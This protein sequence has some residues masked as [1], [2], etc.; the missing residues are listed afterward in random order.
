MNKLKEKKELILKQVEK[1]LTFQDVEWS[2]DV[3]KRLKE[4]VS[5]GKMVRGSLFL[6]TYELLGGKEDVLDT[7][8]AIELVHNT[9]CVHDDVMDKDE[10]RRGKQTMHK[11]YES[12]VSD[13][14]YGYSMAICVGDVGFFKSFSLF[15]KRVMDIVSVEL[16]KCG[17]GQMQDI[18]LAYSSREPTKEQI[19]DV[20][21]HK[22]ARYTFSMPMMLAARIANSYVDLFSKLGENLGI[23]FQ[24]IDDDIGIFGDLKEIGK[25]PGSDIVENKKTL[26]RYFLLEKYPEFKKY[27]GTKVSAKE[28]DL[29]KEKMLEIKPKIQKILNHH[30]QEA[31]KLIEKLPCDKTFFEEL[32]NYNLSRLK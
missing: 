19:I 4:S 11:Q 14:H 1:K 22:T 2:K 29:I 16:E 32:S 21:R 23:I 6:R 5:N 17:Y 10:F 28:L 13:T 9:L 7:A 27:F 24:I 26:H 30:Q 20:Y 8:L 12:I 25:T 31:N 3:V 18:H 15:D